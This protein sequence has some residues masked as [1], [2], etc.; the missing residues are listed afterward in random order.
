[1][2]GFALQQAVDVGRQSLDPMMIARIA[3]ACAL[4]AAKIDPQRVIAA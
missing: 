2:V 3:L 1:V 4:R